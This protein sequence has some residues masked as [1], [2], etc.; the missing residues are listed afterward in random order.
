MSTTTAQLGML[1]TAI[2]A[3]GATFPKDVVQAL[4]DRDKIAQASSDFL[5]PSAD[6]VADAIAGC[7]LRGEDPADDEHVRH[8]TTASAI[9]SPSGGY[10]MNVTAAADRRV[11]AALEA[12][13]DV[14]IGILAEAAA[15]AGA[16]LANAFRVIGDHDLTDEAFILRLG[17]DGARAWVEAR[18]AQQQLRALE[19]GWGALANMTHFANISGDPT[20][21]IADL[22]LET[23]EKVG[24]KA[25]PWAIVC[26][27]GTISL[28]DRHSIRE[29]TAR[30]ADARQERQDQ[31][32]KAPARPSYLPTSAA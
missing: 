26:A 23:W 31:L 16:K 21:R 3:A 19:R 18:E 7:L 2:T 24:R 8:L 9:S 29:R 22:D 20:N 10:S 5:A 11:V 25:D 32:V 15:K 17:P 27:G 4:A 13:A 14:I 30:L 28:A 1:R 6:Q 12:N